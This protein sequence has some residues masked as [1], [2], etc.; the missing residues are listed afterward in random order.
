VEDEVGGPSWKIARW[1]TRPSRLAELDRQA[2]GVRSLALASSPLSGSLATALGP[3]PQPE[4]LTRLARDL[5]AYAAAARSSGIVMDDGI[6]RLAVAADALNG[7][8]GVSTSRR[9]YVCPASNGPCEQLRV[10]RARIAARRT[11]GPAVSRSLKAG[12][13]QVIGVMVSDLFS[14][15]HLSVT[16]ALGVLLE[17]ADTQRLY[18]PSVQVVTPLVTPG[19]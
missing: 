11:V 14:G 4:Q 2:D 13:V 8:A 5:A 9:W 3:K 19:T 10:D 17:S 1:T 18:R 7:I 12:D 16:G 15:N 6:R